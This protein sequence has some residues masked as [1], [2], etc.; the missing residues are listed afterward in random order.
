[1]PHAGRVLPQGTFHTADNR[2]LCACFCMHRRRLLHGLMEWL[3]Q[4]RRIFIACFVCMC[5]P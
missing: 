1:M 5:A 2:C 4:N 3:R